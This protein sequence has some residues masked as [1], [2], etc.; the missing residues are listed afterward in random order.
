[1]KLTELPKRWKKPS[2]QLPERPHRYEVHVA[3]EDAAR[4]KALAEM[5]PEQREEDLLSDLL[6]AA[7]QELPEPGKE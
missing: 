4:L 7:L 3:L 2:D 5:Y 1:M 6:D